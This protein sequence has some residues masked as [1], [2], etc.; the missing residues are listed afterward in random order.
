TG[1]AIITIS[2][3]FIPFSRLT[4]PSSIAPRAIAFSIISCLSIPTILKFGF[5]S[6]ILAIHA[7]QDLLK[8][9]NC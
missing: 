6:Y 1:V 9:D 5:Q 7:L 4:V 8:S 2:A 3:S